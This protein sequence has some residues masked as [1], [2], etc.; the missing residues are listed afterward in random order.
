MA[1]FGTEVLSTPLVKIMAWVLVALSSNPFSL[2]HKQMAAMSSLI[3]ENAPAIFESSWIP[4]LY[5]ILVMSVQTLK[6]RQRLFKNLKCYRVL[7]RLQ[8][9][10]YLVENGL[11]VEVVC[12]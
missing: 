8:K 12:L 5:C 11:Y 2:A 9:N 1:I 3:L 10:A 4:L 7:S 6:A